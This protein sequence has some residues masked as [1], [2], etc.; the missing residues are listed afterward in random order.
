MSQQE[1][2][3]QSLVPESIIGKVESIASALSGALRTAR[4]RDGQ[5]ESVLPDRYGAQ[6]VD[7]MLLSKDLTEQDLVL[8]SEG[9][10]DGSG[11][12]DSFIRW[13]AEPQAIV[14]AW[15]FNRVVKQ[16]KGLEGNVRKLVMEDGKYAGWEDEVVIRRHQIEFHYTAGDHDENVEDQVR[17]VLER[18]EGDPITDQEV[19]MYCAG[20]ALGTLRF[21][22]SR[23]GMHADLSRPHA[24]VGDVIYNALHNKSL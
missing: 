23:L 3:K 4:T 2:N 20:Y 12:A 1:N 13:S 6:F 10:V 15:C 21:I 24:T 17:R 8:L 18:K 5:A 16:V 11:D 9:V 14:L 7:S 19:E 22:E